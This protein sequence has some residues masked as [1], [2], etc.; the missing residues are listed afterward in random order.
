MTPELPESE[1]LSAY[2]DDECTPVERALVA[3]NLER[4]PQWRAAL[5]DLQFA[6][7]AVRALPSREPPSGFIEGLLAAPE[8]EQAA[9]ARARRTLRALSTVAAVAAGVVGLVIATT[10]S[11]SNTAVTPQLST[12][13]DTHGATSSLEGEPIS[14]LATAVVPL[15]LGR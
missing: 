2:L 14:N 15:R 11:R 1:V 8:P 12:L 4:D 13:S 5:A 10:P 3:D 6:R 9:S 7:D